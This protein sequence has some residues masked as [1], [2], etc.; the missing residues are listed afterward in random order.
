MALLTAVVLYALS[1]EPS[2]RA[3]TRLVEVNVIV[4]D[5]SGRPVADL[6]RDEFTVLD[7]GKPQ[8]I[9]FFSMYAGDTARPATEQRP[10][11]V[12]SNRAINGADA[13]SG[14]TIVLL[15]GLNTAFED[16][17]QVRQGVIKFL[18]QVRAEDRIALYSLGREVRVLHD[19][20][21]SP[22]RLLKAV[23]KYRERVPV[24]LEASEATLAEPTS[25]SDNV[26]YPGSPEDDTLDQF[27]QG[28]QDRISDFRN[29]ERALRTLAALEAIANHVAALPGRKNLVWISGSFPFTLGLG[30]IN[31][32]FQDRR[33]FLEEAQQ[34]GRALSNANVAIYPVDARGTAP[35]RSLTASSDARSS[36]RG[37]GS[38]VHKPTPMDQNL[39]S[40]RLLADRTGGRAFFNTN[41]FRGA[42][43]RALDD[44][45]VTYTLGFYPDS[46]ADG[47]YHELKVKVNRSGVEVRYRKD[48]L[49]AVE[50]TPLPESWK[51]QVERAMV[52]PV[53]SAQIGME[54]RLEA[55]AAKAR[56][57]RLRVRLD[58][59]D[60]PLE[61]KQDQWTGNLDLQVA[62]LRAD[63]TV[64]NVARS[65]LTISLPEDQVKSVLAQGLH[66]T[67]SVEPA[68][69]VELVQVMALDEAHGRIGSV[70]LPLR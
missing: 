63:G 46:D 61:R 47:K 28:M 58:G 66:L 34:V 62:Q 30:P 59:A 57:Y 56:S 20:T 1:Q 5:R 70:R 41:D 25:S 27:L 39:D 9:A 23:A 54:V 43:A 11:N 44:A 6:R 35:D 8:K 17:K 15:D 48:Y 14:A 21:N 16:Q 69:G 26:S 4:H 45:K 31:D 67:L 37:M 49:A 64:A 36:Q 24:E 19:F 40:L 68:A 10:A 60:L 22:E 50:G 7:R 13:P 51:A 55:N 38:L 3:N 32:Q 53:S 42:I 65:P 18:E 12:Y 52:S 29:T 2:F 33:T